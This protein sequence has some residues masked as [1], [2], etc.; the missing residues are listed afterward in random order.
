MNLD[1]IILA[2]GSGKRMRSSL[3]KVLHKLGGLPLLG[4]V[5]HAA[6]HLQPTSITVVV[7][8]EQRDVADYLLQ[9]FTDVHIALQDTPKGTAHAAHCALQVL[10]AAHATAST[11]LILFGDTPL[12]RTETLRQLLACSDDLA[13]LAMTPDDAA[14]YGRLI[15]DPQHKA[16]AIVEAVDATPAQLQISLC[17]A[18]M[19]KIAS[20]LLQQL[21]P[22]IQPSRRTQEYYL[23]DL[24]QLAHANHHICG[25]VTGEAQELLGINTRA[26]LAKAES[27]IQQRWRTQA[28]QGGA[29]LMDPP[30][31][32]LSY[33]TQIGQDVMIYPHVFIGPGVKIHDGV[34]IR[35]YCMLTACEI[36]AGV[37]L[38]PC[39]H[40][41][42]GTVVE[43]GARIGNFVEVKN[44][45]IGPGSHVDHLSY[46]GDSDI[47]EKAQIGAGTITCN[48][49]GF[50]KSRTLIGRQAFVGSHTTLIAPVRIGDDAMI[51]AGSVITHDVGTGD[52]AF[53]R[54]R[55]NV[56]TE[57]AAKLRRKLKAQTAGH[58]LEPST[59]LEDSPSPHQD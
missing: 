15:V 49:N 25:V 51:A 58:Q 31:V 56:Q 8:P 27:V 11:T 20:P 47:G 46:I 3:P 4:H 5:L 16:T 39:A 40:I 42:P 22:Q 34:T 21:L 1:I 12:I 53:A 36:H 37:T 48:Y 44:S 19:M 10:D 6:K 57:G 35:P 13:I 54:A 50:S 9:D 38:G 52:L 2:A 28:M 41:R 45:L 14:A 55:Q 17:N 24:V 43:T 33:D 7:S 30:S 26:E 59:H 29:T 18:G 32:F 23:T